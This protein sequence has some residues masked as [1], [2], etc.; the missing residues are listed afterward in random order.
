MMNILLKIETE[1]FLTVS[2]QTELFLMSVILGVLLG[3]VYDVFR[4]LRAMLPPLGKPLPTAV[5]DV[6]YMIISG[7]GI[8]L[9]SLTAAGGEVRGYY[10]LGAFLGGV[11]YILTAGAAVIGIIRSVFSFVCRILKKIYATISRPFF[12][13]LQKIR[14]KTNRVFVINAKKIHINCKKNKKHLKSTG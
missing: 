13:M 8:Y 10:W 5:C 11:I 2:R 1:A 9:F 3:A 14:D 6:I 7:L 4:A 12:V